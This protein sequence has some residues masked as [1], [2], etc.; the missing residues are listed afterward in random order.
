VAANPARTYALFRLVLGGY[1]LV[2]FLALLPWA[3]ELFSERGLVPDGHLS[4]L[5]SLFPNVLA[6][7]DSPLAVQLLVGVGVVAAGAL[8][9]GGRD[10][11][12]ALLGWYV[13]TCLFDRNPLIQNPS[14]PLVGWTL[15]AVAMLPRAPS[16]GALWDRRAG[17]DWELPLPV[18]NAAWWVAGASY[19]YSGL[20]KLGSASWLDGTALWHVLAGPLAR[21]GPLRDLLLQQPV[22][23]EVASYGALGLEILALPLALWRPARPVLWWALLGLHLGLLVTVDFAD[24]SLGMLVT[25]LFLFDPRW[26]RAIASPGRCRAGSARSAAAPPPRSASSAAPTR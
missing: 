21:P 24:L 16:L 9:W 10:R 4:P 11:G 3:P 5:L 18:W 26:L 15:L 23:L 12:A 1:L 6:L 13:L 19:T 14:L 25:H 17:W 7:W 8:A 2:H 22:L 20:T